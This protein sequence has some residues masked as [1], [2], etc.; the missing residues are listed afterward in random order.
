MNENVPKF[1]VRRGGNLTQE[2]EKSGVLPRYVKMEGK[3]TFRYDPDTL[4]YFKLAGNWGV[5][6]ELREGKIFS[7]SAIESVNNKE[8][9]S[10]TREEWSKENKDKV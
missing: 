10:T 8:L 9:T 2:S 5:K 4:T 7:V 1:M 6:F 3:G